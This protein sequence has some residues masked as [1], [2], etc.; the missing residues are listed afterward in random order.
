MLLRHSG[1]PSGNDNPVAQNA[2]AV[3]IAELDW[4]QPQQLQAWGSPLDVIVG[5]DCIY[6]EQLVENLLSVVLH[7]CGPQTTGGGNYIHTDCTP[8]NVPEFRCLRGP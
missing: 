1:L 2:G 8:M 3:S 4:L 6:H 5:T 7:L